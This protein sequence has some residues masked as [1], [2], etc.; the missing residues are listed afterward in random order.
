MN[1]KIIDHGIFANI[2]N[3]GIISFWDG[4]FLRIKRFRDYFFMEKRHIYFLQL[5]THEAYSY[6]VRLDTEDGIVRARGTFQARDDAAPAGRH[7]LQGEGRELRTSEF[8]VAAGRQ[9]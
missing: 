6:R 1:G 8:S 2:D 7:D 9:S 5:A 3:C 4:K